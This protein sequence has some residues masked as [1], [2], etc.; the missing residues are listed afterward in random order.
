MSIDFGWFL[1]TMGD[2]EIIGPPTRQ[3][4]IEYLTEVAKAAEDAGF[5]FALVPVGTTC[6]DAWLASSVVAARTDKLKFL[7]AMRPGFISPTVAAKMSNTLDQL[8]HGRVLINVVTGGF[9]HELAADGDF[10]EHDDRYVRTQEF[11]QVVRKAWVEPKGWSHNGR[12]YRVEEA[13]VYPKP[14]QKPSPPFYFG[15]ASEAAKK[16]GAEESDVYLLWGETL[17]MVAE[18][19]AEMRERASAIGRTLRF[20]MRIL[21][22]TR[23]T[24]D[25]ARAAAEA[26]VANVSTGFQDMMAKHMTNSDSEGEKRQRALREQDDWIGPNL[27]TG[28][29]RARLGVGLAIVGSGE[30]VAARLREYVDLGIDTFILSG[31]P[32][33]EEAQ[34]FGRYVMPHFR[35]EASVPRAP[36]ELVPA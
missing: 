15:G 14:Y 4:T 21:V 5:V 24:D 30:S 3:P 25:E 28:I 34:R 32:H 19:I 8:T 26:M 6:E 10:T 36:S 27:W 13:N 23:E 9:P 12:Y 1:P 16:V 2:T 33:L 35:G 17:P 20:G 29:G 7:V 31:Y 22:I 11:M 18:R